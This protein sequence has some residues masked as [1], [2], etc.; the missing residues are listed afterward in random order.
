M[1][2]I[3]KATHL[4]IDCRFKHGSRQKSILNLKIITCINARC[5]DLG[6][7]HKVRHALGEG[8]R[9]GVTVC[10]RGR[11]LRACDVMLINFLKSY[12]KFKVIFTF[13]L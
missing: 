3:D 11:G 1:L 9:E 10:D 4:A 2:L 6:A 8:V 5:F 12:M 7:V 13:L